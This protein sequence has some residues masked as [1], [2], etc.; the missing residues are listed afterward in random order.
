M[1]VVIVLVLL[2]SLTL[3]LL[4]TA[5]F[6]SC[7]RCAFGLVPPWGHAVV[8]IA[9]FVCLSGCDIGTMAEGL[10]V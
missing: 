9:F 1:I 6:A 8:T 2:L 5:V 4:R 10:K 3:V 7:S